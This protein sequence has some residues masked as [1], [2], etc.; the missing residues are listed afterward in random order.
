MTLRL[1]ACLITLCLA[2]SPVAPTPADVLE[3]DLETLR[4]LWF[5]IAHLPHELQVDCRDTATLLRKTDEADTL[6]FIFECRQ[7]DELWYSVSGSAY[8]SS[9]DSKLIEFSFENGLVDSAVSLKYWVFAANDAFSQWMVVGYPPEG[10]LWVLSRTTTL[11]EA[12][13]N[14]A[15]QDLVANG[16]FEQATL[17][18]KL[19]TT[20]HSFGSP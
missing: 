7:P 15:L 19:E 11:D 18:T 14:Q 4:G 1:A 2:C 5:D 13:V 3:P 17:D 6:E 12:I 8:Q 20:E 16:H 9:D 10:W